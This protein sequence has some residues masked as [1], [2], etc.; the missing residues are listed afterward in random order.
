MKT[1][2]L[3][4]SIQV[5]SVIVIAMRICNAFF[6]YST[7]NHFNMWTRSFQCEFKEV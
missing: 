6:A 5:H 7:Q 4:Q 3:Y 1:L 2:A